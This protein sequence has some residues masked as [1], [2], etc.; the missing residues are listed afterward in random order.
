MTFMK[1]LAIRIAAAAALLGAC[2]T[3]TSAEVLALRPVRRKPERT[4]MQAHD[5]DDRLVVKFR[6]DGGVRRQS[7]Q[8][9]V[10]V[11]RSDLDARLGPAGASAARLRRLF[12]RDDAALDAE[13]AAGERRSHRALPNL[14]LW[15]EVAVAP[16]TAAAV[17]DRLNELPSVEIAVPA[18]RPAPL[19]IATAATT[20]D[21]T[22]G[23]GY[24]LAAPE[25]VG[26]L[27]PA[28]TPGADGAGITVVDVEYS[29]VLDHEDLDLPASTSIDTATPDD[30]F[31]DDQGS[32]GTAVLAELA[33]RDNGYG[34][35]GIV[36]GATLAVAPANTVE[37]K[38]DVARAVNH[39][40]AMLHPGD[41]IL[42]EQQ[43]PVCGDGLYGPVE[44][45]Q[46][47]YDAIAA[48]TALGIVVVEAAGNGAVD[49]DQRSCD[50]L[51]DRSVRDSGAIIVGAA[52][53]FSRTRLSFSSFGSR[54]DLQGWGESVVTAGYG[55]L[56]PFDDARRRYTS[57]FNGTSS[58]S[59]MV[60][61][62]AAAVQSVRKAAGLRPYDPEQVRQLL[63]V[64]GTPQAAESTHIGPRPNL[65][66]AAPVA[67]TSCGDG[68]VD[69]G[70]ECDDGNFVNGDGCKADCTLP[71]CSA[72]P[73]VTC[74]LPVAGGK[75]QLAITDAAS[76]ANDRLTWNWAPG[77]TARADFGLPT[78]T[79]SYYL[80][81]YDGDELISSTT[82]PAGGLCNGRS[83]WKATKKGFEY[84]DKRGSSDGAVHLALNAAIGGK[85]IIQFAGAG[86]GLETPKLGA[87][88]T[89]PIIVQLR[90]Q[91]DAV[92]WE[93][94]FNPP[95]AK[96]DGAHF[97]TKPTARHRI[98]T[99]DAASCDI[100]TLAGAPV[101]SPFR[102]DGAGEGSIADFRVNVGS[103][104]GRSFGR[105]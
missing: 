55:D 61:G 49:L 75:A 82:I 9:P 45:Y 28:R 74:R 2:A 25:G 100:L 17:C 96:N 5:A 34:V 92:C 10:A 14:N 51:F 78:S 3:T 63:Q 97:S 21:F 22:S 87:D 4:V 24:A 102:V 27:D 44:W 16:G 84:R 35:T 59:P 70:E 64:T 105:H 101:H 83:C 47:A 60:A 76:D 37:F 98:R 53:P 32:H 41:V 103:L 26:K 50:G 18:L 13:R 46:P 73:A 30:P 36:P 62:V 77:D 57:F 94:T 90:Q 19:P 71:G 7:G 23:Q 65:V 6:E 1:S 99:C 8:P 31:P 39:A 66:A 54:V 88:L 58:A 42:I 40:A 20:P 93:T 12:R 81:V 79:E 67:A 43:T 15:Y 91:S 38:Y 104:F 85:A 69:A 89:G 95:F 86:A 56:F 72:A 29:W 33:A 68:N 52:D 80:C 11:D 48:A